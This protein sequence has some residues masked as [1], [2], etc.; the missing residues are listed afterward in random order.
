MLEFWFW[1]NV[2]L[3]IHKSNS[4]WFKMIQ[5]ESESFRNN[6]ALRWILRIQTLVLSHLHNNAE[7]PILNAQDVGSPLIFSMAIEAFLFQQQI[8]VIRYFTIT[9]WMNRSIKSCDFAAIYCPKR[10]SKTFVSSKPPNLS[11]ISKNG[12]HH[13]CRL[14]S[15]PS[16]PQHIS[17]KDISL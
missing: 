11:P 17:W 10:L 16:Y 5:N 7:W 2:M 9:C 15:S 6:P 4:T 8:G 3:G 13:L 1:S 14:F 12:R